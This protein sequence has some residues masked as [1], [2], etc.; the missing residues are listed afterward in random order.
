MKLPESD[1]SPPTAIASSTRPAAKAASA[2]ARA[3]WKN[4]IVVNRDGSQAGGQRLR[5]REGRQGRLR[6]P[7]RDIEPG[8]A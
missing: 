8:T 7:A 5:L 6:P 2:F 4:M 1:A 3:L